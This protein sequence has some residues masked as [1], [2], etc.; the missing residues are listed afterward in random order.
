MLTGILIVCAILCLLALIGLVLYL[1]LAL[2]PRIK[3]TIDSV[4]QT[5]EEIKGE[6]P[7]VEETIKNV[8]ETI[9][10]ISAQVEPMAGNLRQMTERI[11]EVVSRIEVTAEKAAQF[12]DETIDKAKFYRDEL[13]EPAVEIISFWRALKAGGS[14]VAEEISKIRAKRKGGGE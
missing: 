1:T 6:I 11:G 9:S 2:L 14:V 5:V 12:S 13:F 4:Q 10:A 7:K 3:N 8:D